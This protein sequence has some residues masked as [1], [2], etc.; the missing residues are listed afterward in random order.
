[1]VNQIILVII[2]SLVCVIFMQY[3]HIYYRY[4]NYSLKTDS[5]L[6]SQ[7]K[8]NMYSELCK[9]MYRDYSNHTLL[10]KSINIFYD[11]MNETYSDIKEIEYSINSIDFYSLKNYLRLL[12]STHFLIYIIFSYVIILKFPIY[13]INLFKYLFSKILLILFFCFIIDALA[14]IFLDIDI[15]LF[16]FFNPNFYKDSTIY[17]VISTVVGF[18]RNLF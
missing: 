14:K 2:V 18:I 15:D 8:V 3:T 7:D 12:K 6:V 13:C 9:E 4:C 16:Q 10:R 5:Y 17:N 1:M 11:F